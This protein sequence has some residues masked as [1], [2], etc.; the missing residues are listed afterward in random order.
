MGP[1]T[2]E[3]YESRAERYDNQLR[4]EVGIDPTNLST[5]EKMAQLREY[6]ESRYENLLNAVY[7]RRGWNN[8]GIPTIATLQKIGIDLPEVLAV[9]EENK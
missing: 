9:V 1:V 7:T 8:D 2:A 3:E 4:E 6:R 5:E